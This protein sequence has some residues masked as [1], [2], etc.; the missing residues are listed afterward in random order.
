MQ[1]LQSHIVPGI[2]TPATLMTGQQIMNSRNNSLTIRCPSPMDF[3][4][5]S[6]S[7]GVV[8]NSTVEPIVAC[9]AVVFVID[10]V[11]FGGD[12]TRPAGFVQSTG[13]EGLTERVLCDGTPFPAE[14]GAAS[15]PLLL[16]GALLAILVA[17]LAT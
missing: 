7:G 8:A 4:V 12:A 13:M 1:T 17:A 10:T 2:F 9:N 14:D 11:L 5:E 6:D 3:G 15:A 16:L